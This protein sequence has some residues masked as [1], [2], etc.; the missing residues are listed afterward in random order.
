MKILCLCLLAIV[1][2][3]MISMTDAKRILMEGNHHVVKPKLRI[4]EY[5]Q[6]ASEA[7]KHAIERQLLHNNVVEKTNKKHENSVI[8]DVNYQENGDVNKQPAN[9]DENR[10][11]EGISNGNT[12]SNETYN[13]NRSSTIDNHHQISIDDFRRIPHEPG[14]TP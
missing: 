14:P 11:A 10:S 4:E 7:E 3:L 6:A 2:S 8:D 1:L 13:Q 9:S 5:A 12:E